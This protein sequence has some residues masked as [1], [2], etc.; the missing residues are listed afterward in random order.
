[1][2]D[3]S[4]SSQRRVE[5]VRF[6]TDRYVVIG[7]VTLPAEG[8]QSRFSDALN[9]P[10]LSFI[11]VVDAEI[12]PID[13]GET[14]RCGFIVVGKAHVTVAYPLAGATVEPAA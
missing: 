7:D 8:Y 13:G 4:G 6:E 3:F 10:E 2:N 9:R 1:M 5:R 14:V 12:T 11:P